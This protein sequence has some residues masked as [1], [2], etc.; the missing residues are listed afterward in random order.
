VP[1]LT[2]ATLAECTRHVP[3]PAYD[4]RRVRVG[5]VHLGVGAFHR[6]HQA[7][8]VDR[9]L[10][11]GQALE[12]GIC[13]IGVLPADRR[14]ADALAAQDH[15]YTLVQ[16]H[17]DGRWEPRVVGSIVDYVFAPDA[18]E[19][20][21]E[22]LAD[23]A[24]RIVSLTIT[25]GGYNLD[26]I[27]GAFIADAPQVVADLFADAQPRSVFGLVTEAL[28]RRRAR[29]IAPFTVMSCDNLE[30]NG[31]VSRR[32]FTSFARLRDRDLA[33]WMAGEVAFPSSM[34]DRITP[35][36]TADDQQ[37]LRERF[38]IEDQAPVFS[39]PF[40]QWVLADRFS[41]RR[42]PFEDAGV[43]LVGDVA[44]Y[45]LMKLRL[46]NASHQALAYFAT[47]HGYRFVHQAAQDP[48]FRS[49]LRGY[50]T[51]EARPTLAPVPGVDLD[52]YIDTLLERFANP[53]VGDRLERICADTS[54]RIPKFLLPV[55]RQQLAAGGAIDRCAAVV[56]SWA[57]Y[58]EG[59]DEQ[60]NRIDV[61]DPLKQSLMERARRERTERDAFIANRQVFG[62]LVEEPRFVAGYRRALASLRKRGAHAT[63]A[64]LGAR[65]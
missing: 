34:V 63:L 65:T 52:A 54:D 46:L 39:E 32:A 15:L 27:S 20:A 51:E 36:T 49:F 2:G 45:E 3:V 14:T 24:T 33:E 6:S 25:E 31:E 26:P 40:V 50:M 43:Q 19:A 37:A 30:G 13:G 56:A 59:V 55:V 44:P 62:G 53:Y 4:R 57:R 18:P 28:A 21:V 47:L 35:A 41:S 42:P 9:L 64:A 17:A 10:N 48:V 60:G 61:V 23:E 8:F 7:M 5:L 12:W 58:A 16:K 29:G 1:R 11:D 38:A 22:R